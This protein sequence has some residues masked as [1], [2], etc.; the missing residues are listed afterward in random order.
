M[1]IGRR[2]AAAVVAVLLGIVVSAHAQFDDKMPKSPTGKA[3]P[4]WEVRTA[5]LGL[6]DACNTVM[7]S[8]ANNPAL[9]TDDEYIAYTTARDAVVAKD[10]NIT[11]FDASLAL[12][13]DRT[14]S[15]MF[16]V[17]TKY[18]NDYVAGVNA[19]DAPLSQFCVARVNPFLKMAGERLADYQKAGPK[20]GHISQ[21][22]GMLESARF[23][24]M[25]TGFGPVGHCSMN[26]KFKKAFAPLKAQLDAMETQIVAAETAKG[27]KF[28]PVDN[29]NLGVG[30]S[31]VDLK[32]GQ[33]MV[34]D[35]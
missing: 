20:L 19:T 29:G 31:Y 26:D 10:A 3:Q 2:V 15:K 9:A 13:R 34:G 33:K 21:A 30:T 1:S 12:S 28:A 16:P 23:G 7:T 27:I 32:T 6:L 24:M 18:F 25:K 8:H 4:K 17:C 11:A 35:Q 14:P 22:R 5:A